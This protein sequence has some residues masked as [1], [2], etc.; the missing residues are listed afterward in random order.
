MPA[1]P[2][3]TSRLLVKRGGSSITRTI[4]RP[5]VLV[6]TREQQP[7]DFAPFSNWIGGA[8]RATLPAG[9]YTVEGME[10]LLMVE[11]KSLADLIGTL[12]TQRNRFFRECEKLTEYKY[13]AILVEASYEN[14]KSPYSSEWTD[15]HPNGISGSLDAVEC[16]Y[17]IQVIYTSQNRLLAAEKM[18]SFLSKHFTYW[19]LERVGLG[20]VLQEGDL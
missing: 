4:P 9:D 5:V 19:H 6:D 14:I 11:R 16:K 15:A 8:R 17:G 12:T 7:I 3:T 1:V 2:P 18:A 20:R 13:R 10:D